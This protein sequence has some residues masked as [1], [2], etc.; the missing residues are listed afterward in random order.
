MGPTDEYKQI[1]AKDIGLDRSNITADGQIELP[2]TTT[3]KSDDEVARDVARLQREPESGVSTHSTVEKIKEKKHRAGV[4][5]R[6]KLHMSKASDDLEPTPSAPILANNPDEPSHSRLDDADA[7]G[8]SH[9]LRDLTHDPVDTI[10]SKVSRQ[11][12]S[13]VA[14]NIAAK[15]VPHGQDVDLVNAASELDHASSEKEKM[16]ATQNITELLKLRQSTFV[17]WTL[18][19][20]VTKVRK[21][22]RDTIQRKPRAAFERKNE[23]GGVDVDWKAYGYHMYGGQ[24]I[25][26]GS[27]P[28][29]PSKQT[30][31]PNIERLLVATSPLQELIMTTRRVYR[32]EYPAETAKYLGIYIVLWYFNLLLPGM[33][34]WL[35]YIVAE[36]KIHGVSIEDL[37]EDV[38]HTE[39]QRRTALSITEFIEK[40][41]DEHWADNILQ[42]LGPWL[43]IQLA[44]AA[45][46][47]E[48]IR[49]FYEWRKPYRTG[50]AL[51]LLSI[52]V[53]I[54]TFL[55]L[56]LLVKFL[57][58]SMGF[59][60]FAL[61]PLSV[62]FPEYRLLVSPT[63]RFLWNIPTHAEWA[64]QY[65]QAEGTRVETTAT[66]APTALPLR[67]QIDA[68]TADDYGFYNAY[69]DKTAGHLVIS[70]KSV[71]FVSRH[72]HS[73]HFT[74]PYDHIQ[75][76]EKV[77]RVVKKK[78]PDKL[79]SDSGKD[80]KIVDI[81]G[82]ETVLRNLDQRDEAWSQI[83][84]FSR[85]NWQVMW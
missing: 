10:K 28:P 38:K 61:F 47:F 65:L 84:G 58:F 42:E 63:K 67:T 36:R 49:N 71:R 76:L 21:L 46:F 53:I 37:R 16:L 44:D 20:H 60:F 4:K 11:G 3:R 18:D 79:S 74:I 69:H 9:N 2:D 1:D 43:M 48:T 80:L 81:L 13:E 77:D 39:D 64:I 23:Q 14:A 82:R 54:T 62:N 12:E 5:I 17:R 66:P 22:P 34:S 73:V 78:V 45:N 7:K 25:G 26:Y 72:P 33:L 19:R 57:T 83:V 75:V 30:I 27:D 31:L 52:G 35:V 55:P 59:T 50:A 41:G 32:W 56:W 70:T 51:C 15:E 40:K 68:A 85:V 29:A 8:E 24:Y 6:E